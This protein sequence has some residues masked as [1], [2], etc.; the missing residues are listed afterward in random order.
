MKIYGKELKPAYKYGSALNNLAA[1]Y[2]HQH[3]MT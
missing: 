3:S 1:R 2:K